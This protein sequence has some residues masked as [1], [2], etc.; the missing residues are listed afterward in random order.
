MLQQPDGG[1]SDSFSYD[2]LSQAD[3]NADANEGDG[4]YAAKC[5]RGS[6]ASYGPAIDD[7]DGEEFID[8]L[9]AD[10]A[11][12]NEIVAELEAFAAVYQCRCSAFGSAGERCMAISAA[13][14]VGQSAAD[15]TLKALEAASRSLTVGEQNSSI[16]IL[17]LAAACENTVE[18]LTF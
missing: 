14:C 10:I 9:L 2:L 7:N 18:A 11:T 17:P 15:K 1:R 8:A 3:Y 13:V 16:S 4:A 6:E 12:C 5:D